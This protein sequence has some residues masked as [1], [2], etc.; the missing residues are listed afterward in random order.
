M[1]PVEEPLARALVLALHID[2]VA[3]CRLVHQAPEVSMTGEV[4]AVELDSFVVVEQLSRTDSVPFEAAVAECQAF[5][6]YGANVC[7]GEHLE[8][9]A[10]DMDDDAFERVAAVAAEAQLAAFEGRSFAV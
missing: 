9:A 4:L 6:H 10:R 1:V 7:A 8:R 5:E 2:R 3:A